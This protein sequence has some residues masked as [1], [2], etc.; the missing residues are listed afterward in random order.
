V[1]PASPSS[2]GWTAAEMGSA[3]KCVLLLFSS[4][5]AL[6]LLLL[7][8]QAMAGA[9]LR[10]ASLREEVGGAVAVAGDVGSR[11]RMLE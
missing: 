6:L 4:S 8:F 9:A 3:I 7:N 5:L 11:F 10:L 2:A 1:R